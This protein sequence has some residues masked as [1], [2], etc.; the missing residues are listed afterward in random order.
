[1]RVPFISV[2]L[3]TNKQI[4]DNSKEK[5]MWRRDYVMLHAK[6]GVVLETFILCISCNG[7]VGPNE[8]GHSILMCFGSIT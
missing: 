1:M 3:K 6:T 5:S 8:L 7:N 4:N 2:A